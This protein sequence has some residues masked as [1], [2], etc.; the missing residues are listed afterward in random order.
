MI[1]AKLKNIAQNSMCAMTFYFVTTIDIFKVN[2]SLRVIDNEN[3][4]MPQNTYEKESPPKQNE[5]RFKNFNYE[6]RN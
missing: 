1:F 3:L 2:I 4:I 6:K 5:I